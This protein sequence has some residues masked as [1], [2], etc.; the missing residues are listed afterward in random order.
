MVSWANR[1]PEAKL[2]EPADTEMNPYTNLLLSPAA[3]LI[4]A[5]SHGDNKPASCL[6]V[7]FIQQDRL[8]SFMAT[9]KLVLWET[10]E[11]RVAR[12]YLGMSRVSQTVCTGGENRMIIPT[13]ASHARKKN[14]K[15]QW[16]KMPSWLQLLVLDFSLGIGNV[17]R[18]VCRQLI[19]FSSHF[20][21]T[22]G[23]YVRTRP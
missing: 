19:L 23:L 15:D 13:S 10:E 18:F 20:Y 11:L 8:P 1:N 22:R 2:C 14:G 12:I 4:S 3:F 7:W 6:W 21:L 5:L 17:E 9:Q 16:I